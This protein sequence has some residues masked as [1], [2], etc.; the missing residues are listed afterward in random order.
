MAV[1]FAARYAIG[2]RSA[3]KEAFAFG[4]A[5]LIVFAALDGAWMSG[6]AEAYGNPIFPYMNN[7]FQSDLVAPEP[8]TDRR[9]LP[10]TPAMD[11]FYPATGLSV[12]QALSA[13][14]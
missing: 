10:K 6:N 1:A 5:G 11:L 14:C 13:N 7:L 8:W 2:K 3:L 12:P 4:V 9:F